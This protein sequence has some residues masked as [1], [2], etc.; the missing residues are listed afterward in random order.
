[1]T[2]ITDGRSIVAVD[3][4]SRGLAFV[5]FEDGVLLDWG[6]RR[7]DGA[8]LA[9]LDELLERYQADALILED[10]EASRTERRSR[11][12]RLLRQMQEHAAKKGVIVILVSRYEVRQ[13]W[14]ERGLTTKQQVAT[15][16]AAMFPEFDPLVPRPRKTYRSEAARTDIFDAASL[17][18]SVFGTRPGQDI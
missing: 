11:M 14:A 10:V 17:V 16:I 7:R 2:R 8:E 1:M 3:P 15:A 13:E 6:T 4:N 18:F 9:I 5:F 12:R